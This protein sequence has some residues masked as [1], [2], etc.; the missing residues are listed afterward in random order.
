[1]MFSALVT[2]AE[3]W[4]KEM[5]IGADHEYHKAV[6][7]FLGWVSDEKAKDEA[8]VAR[9]LA[10]G[11][12]VLTPEAAATVPVLAPAPTEPATPVAAE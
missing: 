7:A 12:K 3:A 1:M 11:Y 6:T 10:K 9:L 5:G 8:A 2:H 4:F